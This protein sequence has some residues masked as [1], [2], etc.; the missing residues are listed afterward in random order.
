MAETF[1]PFTLSCSDTKEVAQN[2]YYP[3]IKKITNLKQFQ[4]ATNN[5]HTCGRFKDDKRKKDNFLTADCL[6]LD[7]DNDDPTRQE[8]WNDPKMWMTMARFKEIFHDVEHILTPSKSHRIAKG[9]RAPRDRFHCYFPLAHLIDTPEEYEETINFL[10][11]LFVRDDGMAWFDTNATDVARFFY[12]RKKA[13]GHPPKHNSGKSIL[14]WIAE[15]PRKDEV[16]KTQLRPT[17]GDNNIARRS[18]DQSKRAMWLA[19]WD[20][21]NLVKGKPIEIYYGNLDIA[22]ERDNY[23]RVRCTSGKHEDK[24]A[25][26]QIDKQSFSWFCHAEG[27]GGN[28]LDF[29]AHRDGVDKSV[30]KAELCEAFDVVPKSKSSTY[31]PVEQEVLAAGEQTEEERIIADLNKK[32]AIISTV[33]KVK[34]LTWG[35]KVVVHSTGVR[36]TYPEMGFMGIQDFLLKYAPYKIAMGDKTVSWADLWM[37]HPNRNEYE[38]IEFDPTNNNPP[39]QGEAWNIWFDWD[40]RMCGY[41]RFVD[42]KKYSQ[43][44]DGSEAWQKC[45]LYL[46]HIKDNICGSFKGV[47]QERAVKYILY[48][49]AD[50]LVNPTRKPITALALRGGQGSGKG[51]FVGKFAELFGNHYVHL[52]SSKALTEQFN[53]HLKDNLLLFADEAIFA[54]AKQDVSTIKG[55]ITEPTR[56]LRKLYA[57]EITVPN[58]TRVILASNEDWMIPSDIDDRRFFVLDVGSGRQRDREYFKAMNEEWLD[59]G[60]EAFCYFLVNTIAKKDDFDEYNWED[61]KLTTTAHWE[62]ILHSNPIVEWYD[63]VL[64]RGYFQYKDDDGKIAHLDIS[65]SQTNYFWQTEWIHEDYVMYMQKQGKGGYKVAKNVLSRK[66]KQLNISYN[67]E[68]RKDREQDDGSLKKYTIWEFGSLEVLRNEWERITQNNRWSGAKLLTNEH[69]GIIEQMAEGDSTQDLTKEVE[70]QKE[71]LKQKLANIKT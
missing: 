11:A 54:G 64:D 53:W 28:P 65:Q 68:R 10:I 52:T 12:G 22:D 31:T 18:G 2:T 6:F 3:R 51:Q 40:T 29:M 34:I 41:K 14:V 23:W 17:P 33:D 61:E 24:E 9:S 8:D 1:T 30:I 21:K 38:G 46:D 62:Q 4:S 55:L 43:I 71:L 27:I 15:H 70:D 45:R 60:R 58:Y 56:Q 69:A 19:S 63:N 36:A 49:M 47:D 5:D 25:S 39:K 7:V 16:M 35:K 50:A 66:L 20:Y 57:D 37:K 26:L 67:S 59:G 13:L 48:W 42:P 44:K 32:H